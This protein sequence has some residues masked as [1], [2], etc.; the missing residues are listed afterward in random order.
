MLAASAL[1]TL[2]TA[3]LQ[4]FVHIHAFGG[5]VIRGNR[6]DYPKAIGLAARIGR[7]HANAL[8]SLGPFAAV[9]LSAN[10]TGSSNAWTSAAAA[11]FLA[12]RFVHA[13]TY[14]A[15]LTVV[16]SAAFYAG[17]V[18]VVIVA[19]QLPWSSVAH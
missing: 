12:A 17:V 15:G 13:V 6:D 9:V 10:A 14:V 8:E 1:L 16:R 11:L 2:A 3:V 4:T 7:A 18:A 19:L 5:S